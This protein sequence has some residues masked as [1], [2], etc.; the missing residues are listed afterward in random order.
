MLD[1]TDL[2]SIKTEFFKKIFKY[3]KRVEFVDRFIGANISGK[4]RDSHH[5]TMSWLYKA[6]CENNDAHGDFIIH[7]TTSS[8][9]ESLEKIESNIQK[10]IEKISVCV[11][12]RIVANIYYYKTQ[13]KEQKEKEIE[14]TFYHIL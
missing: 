1:Y 12:H 14:T 11:K 6:F 2:T 9:E 3:T 10:W 13:K 8:L 7:T 5:I 4:G